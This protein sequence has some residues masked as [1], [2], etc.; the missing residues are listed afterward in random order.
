MASS[1][2]S[3]TQ[4]LPS[5]TMVSSSKFQNLFKHTSLSPSSPKPLHPMASLPKTPQSSSMASAP[6]AHHSFKLTSQSSTMGLLSKPQYPFKHRSHSGSS[7]KPHY[8]FKHRSF[9]STK[10]TIIITSRASSRDSWSTDGKEVC[11]KINGDSWLAEESDD[12]VSSA[13]NLG[14]RGCEGQYWLTKNG[15]DLISSARNSSSRDCEGSSSPLLSSSR[16]GDV[17]A[18]DSSPSFNSTNAKPWSN[19]ASKRIYEVSQKPLIRTS[20]NRP[21]GI[22]YLRRISPSRPN[23]ISA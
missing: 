21:C 2:K 5:S 13:R 14:S 10:G 22:L 19:A 23:F 20:S 6:K 18:T 7:P 4:T 8:T 3:R 12:L 9:S 11:S 16:F 1:S 17:F 15:D